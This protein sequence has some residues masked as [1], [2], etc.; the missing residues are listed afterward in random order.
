[1]LILILCAVHF[2]GGALK[3]PLNSW[4]L[5]YISTTSKKKKLDIA[6]FPNRACMFRVSGYG[7]SLRILGLRA[8]VNKALLFRTLID[9]VRSNDD[10][11]GSKFYGYRRVAGTFNQNALLAI[12]G[13]CEILRCYEYRDLD[14]NTPKWLF[15]SFKRWALG[16]VNANG[17]RSRFIWFVCHIFIPHVF[18]VFAI[19][20]IISSVY[21]YWLLDVFAYSYSMFTSKCLLLNNL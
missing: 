6:Y 5:F 2:G 19:L 10:G 20:M 12:C 3:R 9:H 4:H 7:L 14:L 16:I 8:L 17:K 21:H 11:W 1:M 13:Y 18:L 15:T